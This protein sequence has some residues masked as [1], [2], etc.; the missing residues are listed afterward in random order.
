[1]RG[2]LRWTLKAIRVMAFHD[3]APRLLRVDARHGP[4]RDQGEHI[5]PTATGSPYLLA[6]PFH[7]TSL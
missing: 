7:T 3:A 5:R 6:L 2:P 1:M 4:L